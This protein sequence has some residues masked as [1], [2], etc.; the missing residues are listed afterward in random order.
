M[1]KKAERAM[2]RTARKRGYSKEHSDHYTYGGMRHK[3][4]WK[5]SKA[6]KR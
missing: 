1:P 2:R 3:L 4:G 5:P 6:K